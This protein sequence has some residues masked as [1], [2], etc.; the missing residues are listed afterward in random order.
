MGLNCQTTKPNAIK[1]SKALFLDRDGVINV[2]KGYV[3]QSKDVVWIDGIFDLIQKANQ[4]QFKVIVVSNQSGIARG[5]YS[6]GD[7]LALSDW[8]KSECQQKG[9]KIDAFYYCPHHPSAV[10]NH[11]HKLCDCRKPSIGMAKM[12]ERDLD[13]D[14]DAS[15]MVGDK[16][17]DAQFAINA[18][19]LKAVWFANFSN[20]NADEFN[21]LKAY[22]RVM[23]PNKVNTRATEI[24]HLDHLG[25]CLGLL[26]GNEQIS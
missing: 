18:G 11:N 3:Y 4:L 5:Y 17:T 13:L 19:M 12:A 20:K 15:I 21:N 6:A 23:A 9:G 8:M 16:L 1:K 25:Q 10:E 24:Y 14:I 26:E 7:F 2:D 22:S